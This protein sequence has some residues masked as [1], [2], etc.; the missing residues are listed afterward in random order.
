MSG[1]RGAAYS[2]RSG[3]VFLVASAVLWGTVPVATNLIYGLAETNPLSIGFFRL[4]LSLVLLVPT[5]LRET[6]RQ[7]WRLPRRDL[8]IILLFGL[9]TALYQVCFFA[10]IP[11]VGVT[12]ASLV[13]I[14]TAPVIVTVLGAFL[15]GER[16]T[17]KVVLALAAAIAGTVLLVGI[18]PPAPGESEQLLAGLLLALGAALSYATVTLCSRALTG[19]YQALQLVAIG[20]SSGALVLLPFAL[21][22]GLV[23]RYPPAGWALLLHLGL[24]P[25]AMAYLFFFYGLRSTPVTV[26]TII[27][28]LEPL[29]STML[30][31]LLFG[32]RLAPLGIA[33]AALLLGA[34][35]LITVRRGS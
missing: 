34:M 2:H 21:L 22:T 18:R 13:T 29:T 3:L 8:G 9:A 6:D 35:A 12:V 16:L 7:R 10:A 32:E 33:G 26:A 15:L 20:M 17:G 27:I 23:V 1:D 11:R 4:A 28:L 30:A 19:R 5:A 25:T 31:W 14:C 24:L